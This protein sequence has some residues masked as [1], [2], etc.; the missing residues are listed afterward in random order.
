MGP[1]GRPAEG[2]PRCVWVVMCV[3]SGGSIE[4]ASSSAGHQRGNYTTWTSV[5][6]SVMYLVICSSKSHSGDL[7]K[8][9][10]KECL[11]TAC[12]PYTFILF[13]VVQCF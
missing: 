1:Q 7:S 3:S 9:M 12:V 13:L 10:S 4:H 11:A 5:S 2:A 6:V 8:I